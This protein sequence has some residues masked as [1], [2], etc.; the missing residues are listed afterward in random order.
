MTLQ[1]SGDR[2]ESGRSGLNKT[3]GLGVIRR[4][5]VLLLGASTLLATAALS[6]VPPP[7][8]RELR[9]GPISDTKT[10]M[11]LIFA[12]PAAPCGERLKGSFSVFGS[13]GMP[14]D[15][16]V[17]PHAEGGCSLRFA[18]PFSAL[19]PDVLGKTNLAAVDWSLIGERSGKG[20]P[21]PLH[22][23]GSIPREAVK[24]T[25]SMKSTL[26]RFV[27]VRDVS[28][29]NLGLGSSTVTADLE[30]LQPLSF[31]L[32]FLQA[33]YELAV[34]GKPVASGRR[35]KFVLHAGRKNAL[36]LPV[37]LDHGGLIAAVGQA[38]WSGSVEGTLS[39]AARMRVPA[40]DLDFPFEFPVTLSMR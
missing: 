33:S 2:G 30:I 27:R 13:G 29:G 36:Q 15:G 25:E 28:V 6:P 35:N 23:T 18:L 3:C 21:R 4:T 9:V 5:A 22:W 16:S 17:T 20:T 34:A 39:G 14:V 10:G 19:G 26:R 32:W 11:E 37:S 1:T 12:G 38:A 31:D 40:G 7:S 8:V 24:L